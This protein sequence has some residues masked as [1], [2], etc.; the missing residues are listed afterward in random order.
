MTDAE[1]K[2]TEAERPAPDLHWRRL[3]TLVIFRGEF[4]GGFDVRGC[5]EPERLAQAIVDAM[6]AQSKKANT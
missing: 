2:A 6:N 1:R 5:P 4:E 3:D